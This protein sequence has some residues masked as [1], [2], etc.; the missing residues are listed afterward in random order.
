LA[1]TK[2]FLVGEMKSYELW[3]ENLAFIFLVLGPQYPKL[4]LNGL[5]KLFVILVS[6]PKLGNLFLKIGQG[7]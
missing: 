4:I 3:W 6:S 5:I 7:V 1:F 2:Q